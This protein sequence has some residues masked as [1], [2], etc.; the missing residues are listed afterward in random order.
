[1]PIYHIDFTLYAG[2]NEIAGCVQDMM[3]LEEF[4]SHDAAL[5]SLCRTA[6]RL[7]E[8]LDVEDGVTGWCGSLTLARYDTWC[9]HYLSHYTYHHFAD[10]IAALN[11]FEGYRRRHP[12]EVEAAKSDWIVCPCDICKR[13]NRT[14][15]LH[16]G[17]PKCQDC[18]SLQ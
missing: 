5:V 13:L 3:I 12:D 16:S 6:H 7:V 1:M 9:L 8:M 17:D 14:I 18:S 4:E 15:I 10:P 11:D 2:E